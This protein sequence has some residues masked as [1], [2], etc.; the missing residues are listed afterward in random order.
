MPTVEKW[1]ALEPPDSQIFELGCG[2]GSNAAYLHNKGYRIVGVDPSVSGISM[3][4]FHYPNLLLEVGSTE[5][6]LAAKYGK[7]PIVLSLEVIEHVYSPAEYVK[8]VRDLLLPGGVIILSTPYHGY[9]KNLALALTG[10]LDGHFTALWEGGHIKFWSKETISK[11]FLT[12]GFVLKW[13]NRV[14]RVPQ[15]AKSMMLCFQLE[16]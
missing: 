1:L 13:Y 12:H 6:D 2:N 5:I 14:G 9:I 4:N 11:L 7:Y 3:A 16:I 8:R 15:L 10:K